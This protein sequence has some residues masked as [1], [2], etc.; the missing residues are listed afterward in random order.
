MT[1]PGARYDRY[2][3]VMAVLVAAAALVQA[4]LAPFVF[5]LVGLINAVA[6]ACIAVYLAMY[7]RLRA[8]W[9]ELGYVAAIPTLPLVRPG[10]GGGYALFASEAVDGDPGRQAVLIAVRGVRVR[11][12]VDGE[13]CHTSEWIVTVPLPNGS[14]IERVGITE[15]PDDPA[16]RERWR[17]RRAE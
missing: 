2:F 13:G 3:R 1:P 12:L 7:P 10:D 8:G 15:I 16:G 11:A 14:R 4:V 9:Y 5:G 6:S 17:V